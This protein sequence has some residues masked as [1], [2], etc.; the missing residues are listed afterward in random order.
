M[1]ANKDDDPPGRSPFRDEHEA[2]L[3]RADA[4]QAE[5]D[6][7]RAKGTKNEARIGA[8]ESQLAEQRSRLT[9]IEKKLGATSHP[10][11]SPGPAASEPPPD[12]GAPASRDS[13]LS[14]SAEMTFPDDGQVSRYVRLVDNGVGRI[15]Q[16]LLF[17][18]LAA[19]VL[20]AASAAL[21]DKI[22][23]IHLGRWWFTVVRG[24]TFTIAM[25]AAAFATHQQRHLAMDLVSRRLT[26]RNRLILGAVLKLFTI[27]IA[28]ILLR[29]GLHQRD[30]VGGT[31]EEFVSDKTIVT[32][33]P[34]GAALIILHSFLHFVIDLDYLVRGKLPPERARSGH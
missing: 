16:G 29:S 2:A 31:V 1:G 3:Q 20:T 30:H 23:D 18:L 17:F 28:I 14:M 24:G 7:E 8:L 21:A 34:V 4:L 15:E 10:A 27:A 5:L 33:M 22:F 13:L 11:T 6:A 19:I 9:D 26:P 25:F 12:A 32:M